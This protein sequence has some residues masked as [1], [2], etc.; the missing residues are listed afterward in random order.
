MAK[1]GLIAH[2]M[3]NLIRNIVG[4]L[5]LVCGGL[6]MS[7]SRILDGHPSWDFRLVGHQVWRKI[8]I[9]DGIFHIFQKHDYS[10]CTR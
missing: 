6:M 8:Q 3:Q 1:V 7:K 2:P 9:T 10:T 4:T 5:F